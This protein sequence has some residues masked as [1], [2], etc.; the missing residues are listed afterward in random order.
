MAR[1][2]CQI[3]V[4]NVYAV[5]GMFIVSRP[6]APWLGAG[7]PSHP[8]GNAAPDVIMVIVFN[9][10]LIVLPCSLFTLQIIN[11]KDSKY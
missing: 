3:A 9:W 5:M 7:T 6:T 4:Q 8:Q 10:I 2:I 1:P 11:I